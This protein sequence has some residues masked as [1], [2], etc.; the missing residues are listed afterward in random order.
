MTAA[1]ALE[2]CPDPHNTIVT[3][4][5]GVWNE[6]DGINISN[7]GTVSNLSVNFALTVKMDEVDDSIKSGMMADV[8]IVSSQAKNVLYVPQ[9]AISVAEDGMTRIV[10]SF[11]P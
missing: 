9:Q 3:V 7:A 10:P 2:M 11:D 1:L 6:F 5:A 8:A 4:P